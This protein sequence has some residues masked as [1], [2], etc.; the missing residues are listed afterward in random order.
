MTINFV[1]AID[2]TLKL[3]E[4][5]SEEQLVYAL[6]RILGRE[7]ILELVTKLPRS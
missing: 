3:R 6:A 7:K 1:D 5:F 2:A 4:F